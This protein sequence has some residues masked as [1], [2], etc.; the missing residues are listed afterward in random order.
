MREFWDRPLVTGANSMET[1]TTDRDST[2]TRVARLASRLWSSLGCMPEVSLVADPGC[3]P[4]AEGTRRLPIISLTVSD[5]DNASLAIA[6]DSAAG[7]VTRAG[8]HCAPLIHSSLGTTASGTLRISLG[9]YN[10]LEQIVCLRETLEKVC[11][12]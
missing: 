12:F 3:D 4:F 8:Y 9:P 5:W 7:L 1:P 10:T 2:M 6:L 11:R